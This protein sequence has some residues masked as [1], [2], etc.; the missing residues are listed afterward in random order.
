MPTKNR[1][2]LCGYKS[3][4]TSGL[5]QANIW[6]AQ[7]LFGVWFCVFRHCNI[8]SNTLTCSPNQIPFI[9]LKL[10][11]DGNRREWSAER[12]GSGA[13]A[14]LLHASG[15][16]SKF[17]RAKCATERC[18]GVGGGGF[19]RIVITVGLLFLDANARQRWS[20][21]DT[22]WPW[23][24]G[25]MRCNLVLFEAAGRSNSAFRCYLSNSSIT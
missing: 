23:W 3:F 2:I 16:L 22:G 20:G 24:E 19:Q 9:P 15:I 6:S 1:S 14:K 5:P 17:I 18:M 4:S 25:R 8:L 12:E 21:T 13:L 11:A 10:S 7:R